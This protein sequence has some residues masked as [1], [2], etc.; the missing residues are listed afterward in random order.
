M[1]FFILLVV[2][3]L[4]L[5][6]VKWYKLRYPAKKTIA[7]FALIFKNLKN[8]QLEHLLNHIKSKLGEFEYR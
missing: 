8:D 6:I 5:F 3:Y 7:N 1:A 4:S 2:N